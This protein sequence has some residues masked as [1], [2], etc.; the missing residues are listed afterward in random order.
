MALNFDI[1]GDN[2]NFLRKLEEAKRGV[3][4]AS[5]YIEREGGSID[6]IFNKIAKS[7][8]AI[9]VGLS[10][11]EII[12]NVATIRGQFQQI[13]VALKTMLGSEKEADALMQQ[14]VKTAA[15]TPFDLQGVANGAKQLLAYGD[16]VENV[17]DDLIRLGNIAA[18]LSQPLGDIVYLYGTTMT[19]GRLYTTDLNQFTGRGIPMIHEL[20]KQFKVADNDV[21]GLVESGKVGFPEV[22]KVIQSLTNEGGKFYNLMEEQSKTITGQ[23]SNIED[24]FDMM[25]NNLGKQSEGAINSVLSG[26]SYAIENYEK[27]GKTLIELTATYGAYKAVLIATTAMQRVHTAVMEQVIVEK[28]LAA[29][30]NITLSQSEAVAA[31]RTKLFTSALKA[32]SVALLSNPYALAAASVAALGYGIYKLATYQTD[33]EKAQSKLND[34]VKEMNRSSLSEQRELARLK[35]ELSALTKGSDEYNAVKDKI[36]KGYGKYYAGLDS[37]IEKVGLTEQAYRKLTEAITQSFGAR[38]YE[39][40][41]NQQTEDLDNTMSDNLEKLQ[42]RLIDRLG[43]ESGTYFYTKIRESL[44]KGQ[45]K[46]GKGLSI[47]GLDSNIQKALDVT[48]GKNTNDFVQNS[49]AETYIRN[50]IKAQELTEKMDALAKQRFGVK[51]QSKEPESGVTSVAT[52]YQQDVTAAKTAWEKAK[53]AYAEIIKDQKATAEQVKNARSDVESAE[54]KYKGLTGTQIGVQS[55][56]ASE[57]RKQQEEYKLLLTKQALEEKRA[58]EDLYNDVVDERIKAMDD[59]SE[60]VIAQIEQ[61]FDKEMQAV[62]R[63]KENLLQKKIDDA[64]SAFEANPQNKKKVFDASGITLTD[65]EIKGL[66]EKYKAVIASFDKDNSIQHISEIQMMWDY[67]KEYGTFQQQKL[68][69]AEEYNEKIAKLGKGDEWQK[70][71]LEKQKNEALLEVDVQAAKQDINWQSVFGDLGSILQEQIQPTIDNLKKITQSE[72]FKNS[73]VESQQKIYEILNELEK[74]SSSF[75]KDMFKN[76]ADDLQAFRQNLNAYNDAQKKEIEASNAL[77][78]AQMHLKEVQS[79]GGDITGAKKAVEEAQNTFDQASESTKTFRE[80][81]DRSAN[82]LNESSLKAKG[83]LE[84]FSSSLSKLKS[85]SLQQAFEGIEGIGKTLGGKIGNAIANIDP[86]GIIGAMLGIVDMLK[87]GL[88]SIFVN[89]Q[90]MV[91]G[92]IEGILNDVFSGDIIVKPIKNAMSHIGNILN[93]VTFGGFKSWTNN[94]NAKEVAETTNRLTSSNEILTQSIDALKDEMEKARGADTVK[95]YD[96]A[97]KKQKELIENTG[98]ILSAQMGYHSSHHSNSYYIDK[99]MSRED[100]QRV[101]D[102]TGKQV[103]NTSDLWKLTPED[104][105]KV[106]TLTDIWDKI[107]NGGKYDKSDYIDQYLKLAGTLEQMET[108]LQKTLTQTTFDDVYD[109]FVNT[110]MD[111]NKSASDFAND[112]SKV[113]MKAMLSNMIGQKYADDLKKWYKKFADDMEDGTLDDK[114]RKALK[115]EYMSYVNAAIKERDELAKTIGYTSES[116]SSQSSSSKGYETMSQDMGHELSGRFT[117]V[118]ISSEETKNA[119]LSVLVSVSEMSILV[120]NSNL[121]LS[122]IRN[123]M[124]SSNSFLEDLVGF[125]K[126]MYNEFGKKLENIET[127]TK[128]FTGK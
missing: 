73:S 78:K 105:K 102:K 127:S 27:I 113:F 32:N 65:A 57:L 10:V 84:G 62:D 116:S 8:A 98:S 88:S 97:V 48:S 95:V 82:D 115:D 43:D 12:S 72:G 121:T 23:I 6:E 38:Q 14:L 9:G 111:M 4:D 18:G 55:K 83:A 96:E 77:A 71:S 17:N 89:L 69:I 94:S 64:R 100:W 128:S 15:T 122:E 33:A 81:L 25:F 19:Q 24:A 125:S 68:A 31:A 74:H 114:E 40:F 52:T 37:E 70:K 124:I 109:N 117:A 11:K 13:E 45:L 59:G 16:S 44:V 5:K 119:M 50:I 63:E 7:A 99:S 93:T 20:A 2:S 36:I 49:S 112:L 53:K 91:F 60:K 28:Q 120:S 108:D 47:L 76:V 34:A 87:D 75:G 41:K 56:Q 1:T 106:A 118:Q 51:E 54:Q 101:S 26:V 42:K 85:G 3:D 103:S 67:L 104:L 30:A 110:L 80:N 92:S 126:K 21:K 35:G 123:L 90:D 66:E 86:T 46:S 22:Q 58:A 61:N 107:Y 79:K 39:K 29:M